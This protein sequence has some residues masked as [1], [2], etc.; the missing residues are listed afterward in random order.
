MP[1]AG[2]REVHGVFDIGVPRAVEISP[3]DQVGFRVTIGALETRQNSKPE[4]KRG[5]VSMI[6]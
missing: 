3:G 2:L 5:S 1:G 4:Q 6:E